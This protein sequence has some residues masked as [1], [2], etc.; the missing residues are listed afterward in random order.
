MWQKLT[1]PYRPLQGYK[2]QWIL[3]SEIENSINISYTGGFDHYDL[4]PGQIVEFYDSNERNIRRAGRIISQTGANV[5]VDAPIASV[6]G[7]FF[8]LTL[9]DGS[10]HLT[11]IASKSGVNIVMT[12]A[13]GTSAI[14]N[15]TFIA[16]P[17]AGRKLYKVIKID[18]V[19][20]S[21]FSIT[22]QLYNP[23]KY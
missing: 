21:Q 6:A 7:D 10:V 4:R 12:T 11:T 16:A 15:A 20:N 9:S 2:A 13:P 8:S 18:E 1:H 14:P 3:N 5:V 17:S 23:D 19:S 22:L